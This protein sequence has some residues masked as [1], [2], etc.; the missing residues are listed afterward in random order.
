MYCSS[1]LVYCYICYTYCWLSV[2]VSIAG[3]LVMVSSELVVL[4]IVCVGINT[5]SA[6]GE[7]KDS[8]HLVEAYLKL[9]CGFYTHCKQSILLPIQNIV[10]VN[11][12]LIEHVNT[13]ATMIPTQTVWTLHCSVRSMTCAKLLQTTHNMTVPLRPLMELM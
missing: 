11:H 4:L 2:T 3:L 6:Q 7:P 8:K 12:L 5:G 13:T 1:Q 9:Q 10:K